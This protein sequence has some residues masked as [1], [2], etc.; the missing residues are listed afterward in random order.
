MSKER[1]EW[2]EIFCFIIKIQ[3]KSTIYLAQTVIIEISKKDKTI[4]FSNDRWR[5]KLLKHCQTSLFS[6]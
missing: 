6:R 5:K 4:R 1:S 3:L 2:N